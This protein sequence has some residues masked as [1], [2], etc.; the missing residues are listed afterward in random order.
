[1]ENIVLFINFVSKGLVYFIHLAYLFTITQS[2]YSITGLGLTFHI[3]MEEFLEGDY[4]FKTVFKKDG[5]EL[6][7]SL[8]G[9]D[10]GGP[11]FNSNSD[12]FFFLP[13]FALSS[14]P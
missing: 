2:V 10:V 14:F 3:H 4:E 12:S 8:K 11:R 5:I 13:P 6:A 1:L 9:Q 7:S